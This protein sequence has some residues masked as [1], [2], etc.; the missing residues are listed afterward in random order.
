MV[1]CRIKIFYNWFVHKI[2]YLSISML[3]E[4]LHTRYINTHVLV[5]FKAYISW[6]ILLGV[7]YFEHSNPRLPSDNNN[8]MRGLVSL[9]ESHARLYDT[10]LSIPHFNNNGLGKRR[11]TFVIFSLSRTEHN[12]N[13]N[14]M[15]NVY[16]II[17]F[18]SLCITTYTSY[19]YVIYMRVSYMCECDL[20]LFGWESAAG[21]QRHRSPPPPPPVLF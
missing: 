6:C 3:L 12:N 17:L 7:S 11:E 16:N 8:T 9:K 4:I 15:Y 21:P 1:T 2:N 13:N 19:R 5:I 20:S 18:R 14:T 10:Y